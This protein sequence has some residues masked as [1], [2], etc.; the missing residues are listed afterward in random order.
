MIIRQAF[1]FKLKTTDAIEEKFNR[2]AGHCRFLWNKA[3]RLNMDRLNRKLPIMRYGELDFWSK[4][5]KTSEEC[6]FL[7]ECHSQLLQQK[8]K[9][10]DKAFMDAFDK[11]QPKKKLPRKKKK[12]IHDSFRYPQGFKISGNRIFLPKMGWVGFFKSRDI[13][14]KAKNITISRRAGHWYVS[15]QTEREVKEPVHSSETM[16]GIDMGI[17]RF[18]TLSTGEYIEAKKSFR[19]HE[20][21]LALAQRRLSKKKKFSSNWKKQR[22]KVSA[23]HA[24]IWMVR[25]DHLHKASHDISKNHAMIV[26]EDLKI[27][28]MSKSAKGTLEEAGKHVQAKSGLNKSILDQGWYEFRRQLTYK[29]HWRGGSVLLVSPKNTSITCPCCGLISKENRH[30]QSEFLCIECGHT[31]HADRVGAF[32]VLRAGHAQLACGA[33]AIARQ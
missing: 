4:V 14:G 6:A 12:G 8:L 7:K 17:V 13:I 24:K 33:S 32:N 2:F 18:A 19:M 30:T 16:V 5:W 9:D 25:S 27:S 15:I 31:D 28:N 10:L 11:L 1:K 20:K 3:W 21:K 29:Q 26:L 23:I 22:E